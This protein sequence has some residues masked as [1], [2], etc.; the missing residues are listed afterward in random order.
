MCKII[1]LVSMYVEGKESK[2]LS[3]ERD[4]GRKL[5]E[6]WFMEN[7]RT[8]INIFCEFSFVVKKKW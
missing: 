7:E 6:V 1:K 8:R 2:V 3:Y 4:F 5:M